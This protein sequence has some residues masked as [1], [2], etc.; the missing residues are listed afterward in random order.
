MVNNQ[1]EFNEKYSKEIKEIK[2]ENEDFEEQHLIIENYPNLE[3]VYLYDVQDIEK[4]ILKNLPQLQE[5]TIWD[6][7]T[8]ELV[9]TNCPQIQKLNI[10]QNNLTSLEFLKSLENL[11]NLEL[12]GNFKIISGLEYLP[13]NWEK[14]S[15]ENTKLIE[16]LKFYG[17]N[18]KTCKEDAQEVFELSTK[19]DFQGL[20][21]KFWDL[22]KSRED[23]KKEISSI[24]KKNQQPT[25]SRLIN[26]KELVLNLEREFKDK[27]AKIIYLEGVI[28]EISGLQKT[29]VEQREL[30]NK[31]IQSYPNEKELLSEFV[32]VY[33]EFKKLENKKSHDE[34]DELDKLCE[35][36]GG[37][38]DELIKS[39]VKRRFIDEVKKD[40]E[41]LVQLEL[42]ISEFREQS[43]RMV[44]IMINNSSISVQQGHVFLGNI[45]GDQTNFNYQFGQTLESKIEVLPKK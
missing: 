39:K 8:K 41:K 3:K 33:I 27:E 43:K 19:Q 30:I 34:E 42:D 32:K 20:I 5:C 1:T 44:N 10:R 35:K 16:V 6:C 15:H 17:N 22:K 31:K 28:N 21:K 36:W 24:S 11:E 40:C 4:V 14:F 12:D 37:T 7:G 9:I 45:F 2:E 29:I 38:S 25:T 13:G 23:L 26:T 18:W